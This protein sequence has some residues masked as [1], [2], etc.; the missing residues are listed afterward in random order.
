MA[1]KYKTQYKTQILNG[2][3]SKTQPKHTCK[4]H[5]CPQRLATLFLGGNVSIQNAAITHPKRN[6]NA[7]RAAMQ[8]QPPL[9]QRNQPIHP[10]QEFQK[11][12]FQRCLKRR[13][14]KKRV[15]SFKK[16][17]LEPLS[18][19]CVFRAPSWATAQCGVLAAMAGLALRAT[20][21]SK[22]RLHAGCQRRQ[23]STR[24]ILYQRNQHCHQHTHPELREPSK[25]TNYMSPNL[26]KWLSMIL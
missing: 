13:V 23:G 3:V 6:Q 8:D 19:L 20:G 22:P 11:E 2:R 7:Q 18:K 9:R 24:P 25:R 5:P 17:V 12:F 15:L 21:L 1:T 10:R 16:R 4:T 26:G 14:L